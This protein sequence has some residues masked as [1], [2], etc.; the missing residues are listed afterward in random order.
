MSTTPGAGVLI[1]ANN[2]Y[3]KYDL[4][5]VGGFAALKGKTITIELGDAVGSQ[6]T[7]PTQTKFYIADF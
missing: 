1:N 3:L 2:Q 4:S 7:H 6:S 5:T